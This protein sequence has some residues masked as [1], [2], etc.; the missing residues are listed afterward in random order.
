MSLPAEVRKDGALRLLESV[1]SDEACDQAAAD[2]LHTAAAP[3][4]EA[5]KTD[6]SPA[7]SL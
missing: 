2:W 1:E 6:P 7:I 5:L 3:A 4:F